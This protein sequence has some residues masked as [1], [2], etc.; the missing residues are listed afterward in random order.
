VS[1]AGVSE[2]RPTSWFNN[3]CRRC[4]FLGSGDSPRLITNL[5]LSGLAMYLVLNWTNVIVTA[6][7]GGELHTYNAFAGLTHPASHHGHTIICYV[8]AI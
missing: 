4:E 1:H 6:I 3:D 7:L 5:I 8:S 2:T